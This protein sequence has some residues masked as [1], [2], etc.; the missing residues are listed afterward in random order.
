MIYLN[1]QSHVF[2]GH[3]YIVQLWNHI[4][5]FRYKLRPQ[6]SLDMVHL[7]RSAYEWFTNRIYVN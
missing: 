6:L 3:K 7:E 5:H 2:L 4:V 1:S